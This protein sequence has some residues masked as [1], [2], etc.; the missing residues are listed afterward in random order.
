MAIN[1][2]L[3][4]PDQVDASTPD[5][6]LG[7]ARNVTSPDDN[8]ATPLDQEWLN[9]HFGFQ[10][11]LLAEAGIVPSGTP[12]NATS[13][14]YLTALKTVVASG[15]GSTSVA[16]YAELSESDTAAALLEV[17]GRDSAGDGAGG[18][19]LWVGSDLSDNVAADPLQ[20]VYVPPV[21]DGTGA[22]GAWVRYFSGF[23]FP[24]WWGPS[25]SATLTAAITSGYPLDFEGLEYTHTGLSVAVNS[26]RWKA[27]GAVIK[28]VGPYVR[29]AALITV[30][31]NS[32]HAGDLTFDGG[33]NCNEGFKILTDST[34]VD[35]DARPSIVTTG[36]KSRN[37]RRQS[38]AFAGG[39]GLFVGGGFRVVSMSKQT[40]EDCYMSVGAEVF[41]SQGIF[42][43]TIASSSGF[44]P[45]HILIDQVRVERI[46]SDDPTYKND[47]D[48]IRIFQDLADPKATC[49][50]TRYDCINVANR[51]IK[52]HS[53]PNCVIDTVYRELDAN[54]I[55]QSGAFLN[56]DIDA[57]QAAATVRN[58]TFLYDGAW[59]DEVVR[60]YTDRNDAGRRI[61][62]MTSG[63]TGEVKNA[64]GN[65]INIVGVTKDTTVT[66]VKTL[67]NNINV[68]GDIQYVCRMSLGDTGENALVLSN[69]IASPTVAA[70][71][72][73]GGD[74]P[75][76]ATISNI[77]NTGAT[78]KPLLSRDHSAV[79]L[80][81]SAVQGFTGA[82]IYRGT[83]GYGLGG[84]GDAATLDIY[85]RSGG[86]QTVRLRGSTALASGDSAATYVGWLE[87]YHQGLDSRLG[88]IGFSSGANTDL[89]I[90]NEAGGDVV[91]RTTGTTVRISA[92]TVSAAGFS[93][94]AAS[95][96]WTSGAGTPE[97]GVT[98]GKGSM[99]SRTDGTPEES[100]YLKTTTSGNTGWK[101]V[102]LTA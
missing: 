98:A 64:A 7:K 36:L 68:K 99:Y 55:P 37:V 6:P 52:L 42:G 2:T 79:K 96:S 51:M 26:I 56:P 11:A 89:D 43:L 91:I 40:I 59:H 62:A 100:L 65:L 87:W 13:S 4:Y 90:R 101:A 47:Q 21:S 33:A 10:Q 24:R 9:D 74:A 31:A 53:A 73:S 97:A 20:G 70:V 35:M 25:S 30:S 80:Q 84:G 18:V 1:L 50:V 29:T 8:Y 34:G 72:M 78:D 94:A 23:A 58:I 71:N 49:L 32:S 85:P 48:G 93:M 69:V 95:V 39:D 17:R 44:Y 46:W 102:T 61:T 45:R 92:G 27:D 76:K 77:I 63:I 19:F 54:V 38:T 81:T 12:D 57:Q 86:G 28:Y 67:I 41:G 60:N 5:Y 83:K 75:L 82:S 14:Q 16:N 66:N 3:K 22:S 88:F 15:R